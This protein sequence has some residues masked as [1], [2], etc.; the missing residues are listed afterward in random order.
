MIS[1]QAR[2]TSIATLV[3][4][5]AAVAQHGGRSIGLGISS[6]P[7][8]P[9]GTPC[10]SGRRYSEGRYERYPDLVAE[11]Q[12]RVDVLVASAAP[13]TRAAKEVTTTIPIVSVAGPID[14]P[15][16]IHDR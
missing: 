4:P 14:V 3:V 1:R 7:R 5:G 15:A 10:I 11:F 13:A 16:R 8:P 9:R 6:A 2:V 12:L